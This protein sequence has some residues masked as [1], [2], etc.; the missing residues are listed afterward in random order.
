MRVADRGRERRKKIHPLFDRNP[1]IA[2]EE[3][4]QA[5]PVHVLGDGGPRALNLDE[6]EQA[7]E[8]RMFEASGEL[9]FRD[10][11]LQDALVLDQVL[12]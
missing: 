8:T 7:D 1:F 12:A 11:L 3:R 9:G 10:E 2:L 6:S 4:G 5:E